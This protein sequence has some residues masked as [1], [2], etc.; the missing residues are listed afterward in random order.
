MTTAGQKSTERRSAI[1]PKP[2]RKGSC[3]RGCR[4]GRRRDGTGGRALRKP[5]PT[6]KRSRRPPGRAGPRDS[7]SPSVFESRHESHPT[8]F[9]A[10]VIAFFPILR[11]WRQ[12]SGSRRTSSEPQRLCA[13]ESLPP[14]GPLAEPCL[15]RQ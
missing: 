2:Y 6:D 15:W 4:G 14:R 10:V 5:P 11:E 13:A 9:A 3:R 8:C 7:K 1:G 12:E